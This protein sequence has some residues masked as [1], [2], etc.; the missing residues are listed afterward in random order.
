MPDYAGHA[1]HYQPHGASS[2]DHLRR[3]AGGV[4]HSAAPFAFSAP[5]HPHEIRFSDRGI[6]SEASSYQPAHHFADSSGSISTS[7]SSGASSLAYTT[8]QTNHYTGPPSFA[9]PVQHPQAFVPSS[10]AGARG[11]SII[12]S[13]SCM[14]P[15]QARAS[16]PTVIDAVDR[17]AFAPSTAPFLG[18]NPL[19]PSTH[20]GYA[21]YPDT[22]RS[23]LSGIGPSYSPS[24]GPGYG[25]HHAMAASVGYGTTPGES[26]HFPWPDLEVLGEM[27]C[28]GQH[29]TPEIHAKVEKGFFPSTVDNKWTCYRRNY[30]SVTSNFELHG[31]IAGGRLYLKRKTANEQIMAMGMRLS[32]AVDGSNG[33]PIEL[34]QYTPKRDNGEKTKIDVVKVSPTPSTGRGEHSLSPNGVYQVPMSTFHPTGQ[35][36]GPLLPLQNTGELHGGGATPSLSAPQLASQYGFSSASAAAALQLPGQHTS[37]SFERV[38][39]K[40]ATANNGKRRASQQYFHLIVELFVD[41]RKDGGGG[42]GEAANWVKV[43]QRVSER[44]V[45]RG[46]S[47]SHYQNEGQHGQAG[48]GGSASGSSGYSTASGTYGGTNPG[49]FRGS[50]SGGYGGGSGGGGGGGYGASGGYRGNQYAPHHATSDGS[51]SSPDSVDEGAVDGEPALDAVM[52]DTERT[53]IQEYEGYQYYPSPMYEN[54][55]P[56]PHAALP[57][58]AKL[59]G[60]VRASTATATAIDPRPYAV[61]AEYADAVPGAQWALGGCGRFQG[62]ASSRGFF[63]DLSS[64][65][66]T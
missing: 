62:V 40:S 66:Y 52:S 7:P 5:S 45:V 15:P 58:L 35:Y 37:H 44:I 39:F 33:K 48:R 59:E 22:P 27:T 14:P 26:L 8:Y 31:N 17:D 21:S 24:L 6:A 42:A 28:E 49:A 30:F 13:G 36:P 25:S 9:G 46:R 23:I 16:L 12:D 38:Q 32:A 61:K 1:H 2:L 4:L 43:A 11:P 51:G 63:P 60:A 41:I 50:S 20:E 29:V 55:P 64:A 53:S 19:S 56:P 57:P 3:D 47:P 54:L 65:G 34:V 18:R 10:C